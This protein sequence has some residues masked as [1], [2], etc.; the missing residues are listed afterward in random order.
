MWNVVLAGL[1]LLLAYNPF[2][3]NT[4]HRKLAVLYLNADVVREASPV[5]TYN[6]IVINKSVILEQ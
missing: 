5:I 4:N 2:Y 3:Y 6:N 1:Q